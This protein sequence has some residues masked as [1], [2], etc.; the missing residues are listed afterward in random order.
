[1]AVSIIFAS[2][3][4]IELDERVNPHDSHTGLHGTLQLLHLA[5]AWLQDTQL[6]AIS[7]AAL[8]QIQAV[9]LIVLLARQ[10]LLVF[11]SGWSWFR[12]L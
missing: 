1:M 4:R 7:H 6:Q 9:V 8:G 10:G 12:S 3:L 2:L 5:H 11:S